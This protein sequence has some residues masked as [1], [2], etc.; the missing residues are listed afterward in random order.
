MTRARIAR[1]EPPAESLIADWYRQADLLD[2]YA[3]VAPAPVPGTMRALAERAL[4][5]PPTWFRVL[6]GMRDAL[7]R[8]LG[9]KTTAQLRDARRAGDR[10][11]F[12]PVLQETAD[13]I[14]IGEDD[15]HL[16]F[17]MSLRRDRNLLVATTVVR[18]HNA[19]GQ[20]YIQV[21]RPFHHLVVRSAMRRLG[22][23]L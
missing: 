4:A 15:R 2:S 21:I 10:I 11:D 17:R 13:E 20:A 22:D 16:D 18:V 5:T 19:V 14:V 23:T 8:P 7:M 12:F 9:V 3:V 1:V 6:I